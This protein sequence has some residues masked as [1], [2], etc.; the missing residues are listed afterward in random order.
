[1]PSTPLHT[2]GCLFTPRLRPPTGVPAGIRELRQ[3]L[4]K[5][6][7]TFFWVPALFRGGGTP[8]YAASKQDTSELRRGDSGSRIPAPVTAGTCP[9]RPPHPALG[10]GCWWVS[11]G[12][13]ASRGEQGAGEGV[14]QVVCVGPWC[15]MGGV[16]GAGLRGG[17]VHGGVGTQPTHRHQCAQILSWV[18]GWGPQCQGMSETTPPGLGR[19]HPWGWGQD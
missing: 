3:R 12:P 5:T 13:P 6:W 2:G 1:M 4:G 17:G 10:A 8:L 19:G 9:P 14:V 18:L 11:R 16:P 7:V 15:L